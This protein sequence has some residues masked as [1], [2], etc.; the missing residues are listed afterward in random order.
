MSVCP[1]CCPLLTGLF[2]EASWDTRCV[3][4]K[5]LKTGNTKAGSG[6]GVRSAKSPAFLVLT[7]LWTHSDC[8]PIGLWSLHGFIEVLNHFLSHGLLLTLWYVPCGACRGATA[9]SRNQ[10][11]ERVYTAIVHQA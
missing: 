5:G 7:N 10:E 6:E 4:V 1:H 2:S 8:M 11:S 9:G 3:I